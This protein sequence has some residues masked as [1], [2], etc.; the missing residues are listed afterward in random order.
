MARGSRPGK[1]VVA[2]LAVLSLL[3][4]FAAPQVWA[5]AFLEKASPPVGSQSPVAPA[6]LTLRFTE[7]V[8]P[9]FCTIQ[10][11]DPAGA[12]VGV[13]TPKPI[14][15]GQALVVALPKL[16]PGTYTVVWHVTS[17]DTHKTEGRFQF[18]IGP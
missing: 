12:T 8:E 11:L 5:H 7:P 13:A 3:S 1:N 6:E 4:G 18:S 2:R 10:L 16:P 15:N 14:D 17:V 9:L